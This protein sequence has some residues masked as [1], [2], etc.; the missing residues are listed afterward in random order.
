M[1][2]L[3]L[4]VSADLLPGALGSRSGLRWLSGEVGGACLP[5]GVSVHR[6]AVHLGCP[7]GAGVGYLVALYS[8]VGRDPVDRGWECEP[9]VSEGLR[10][11]GSSGSWRGPNRLFLFLC[12][13]LLFF[14]FLAG[15]EEIEE[16]HY[17]GWILRLRGWMLD[18][19]GT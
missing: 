16:P 6:V 2:P 10:R 5:Q 11:W 14:F 17:D 8:S 9:Y 15:G 13:F 12:L 1:P 4:D 3:G 19:D 7:S 18:G